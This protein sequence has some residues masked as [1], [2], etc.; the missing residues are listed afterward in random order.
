[1]RS[2]AR[3]QMF[4]LVPLASDAAPHEILHK[5]PH[6]GKVKVP[7]EAVHRTLDPFVPIIVDSCDD[8]LQKG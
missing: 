2:P 4:R 5:A 3:E 8:L 1:M 7:A 6:V